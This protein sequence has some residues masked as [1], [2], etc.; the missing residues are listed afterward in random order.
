M[1][2]WMRFPPSRCVLIH[3]DA[4]PQPSWKLQDARKESPAV[5]LTPDF[6]KSN[7]VFFF[8]L[9]NQHYILPEGPGAAVGMCPTSLQGLCGSGGVFSSRCPVDVMR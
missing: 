7:G 2:P 5:G 3:E 9:W 8:W 4:T 1:P 6:K